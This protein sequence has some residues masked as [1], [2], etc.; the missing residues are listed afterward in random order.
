MTGSRLAALALLVSTAAAPASAS[1]GPNA[2]TANSLTA[3]G[4]TFQGLLP[5]LGAG[6][7]LDIIPLELPPT[8]ARTAE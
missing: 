5:T 3:N 6:S 7:A 8:P 2:L 4:Q 1:I